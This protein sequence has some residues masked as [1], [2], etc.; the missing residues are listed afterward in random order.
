MTVPAYRSMPAELTAPLLAPPA[1]RLL[2]LL[3]GQAAMCLLDALAT[4]PAYEAALQVCNAD[5]R[6]V[7][8]LGAT[9]V[10]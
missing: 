4:L 9:D 5:R 8:L 10:H 6:R 3:N 7:A 1:P 2:C